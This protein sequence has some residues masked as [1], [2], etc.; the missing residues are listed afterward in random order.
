MRSAYN[1]EICLA[2]QYQCRRHD[3]FR[4]CTARRTHLQ[5]VT[6]PIVRDV[7]PDDICVIVVL[8]CNARRIIVKFPLLVHGTQVIRRVRP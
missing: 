2:D 7:G 6:M 3:D 1:S 4:A 8:Q 5:L